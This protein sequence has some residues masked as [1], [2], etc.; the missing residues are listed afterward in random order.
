M[1]FLYHCDE[2]T[3]YIRVDGKLLTIPP[4]ELFEVPELRGMDCNNN[5]NQE[6]IIPPK[7]VAEKAM[8]DGW[9]HGIV[10]VPVTKTKTGVTADVE[11]AKIAARTALEA[12]EDTSL[13]KYVND[14]Q[15][16]VTMHNKPAMAP[17]G[18]ILKI[19]Q[20]RGIDLKKDFNIDP[21]GFQVQKGRDRDAE[22]DAM[23]EQNALLQKQ[24][25]EMMELMKVQTAGKQRR[26][27]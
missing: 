15:E 24:M 11:P 23:R 20:K 1:I 12:A 6:Y 17:G 8:E 2:E 25:A 3:A 26:P 16:R 13:T 27:E 18:R 5:G 10:L 14:Q 22:M 19:I 4:N 7:M 9:F 21:P